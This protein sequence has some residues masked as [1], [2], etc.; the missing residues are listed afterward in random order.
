MKLLCG[1]VL[2]LVAGMPVQAQ[3]NATSSVQLLQANSTKSLLY[4]SSVNKTFYKVSMPPGVKMRNAGRIMTIVGGALII[5]GIVMVSN[6]DETYYNYSSTTSG[7]YEDG[8]LQ[9]ALGV[10]MIVGG[11]GLTVPGIIMW[12]K[13]SKRYKHHLEREAA[14]NFK[15]TQLSLS[16]RF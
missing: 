2:V 13:G 4:V 6:A 14:F 11:T 16:Y 9:G 1:L 8:D 7:N 5:G 12:S 10:V 15:G 3:F